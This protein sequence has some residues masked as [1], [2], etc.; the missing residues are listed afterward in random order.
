MPLIPHE[1]IIRG[2]DLDDEPFEDFAISIR[3]YGVVEKWRQYNH[4]YLYLNGYKY[5]TM[6]SPIPETIVIN[7]QKIFNEYDQIAEVYDCL[8]LKNGFPDENK[9]VA[10]LIK[11]KNQPV[12]EIGCGTGLLLEMLHIDKDRYIGIDPSQKMIEKLKEKHPGYNTINKPFE[13]VYYKQLLD[14]SYCISIFGSPSYIMTEYLQKINKHFPKLF[15][16]FYKPDYH[17][18]TYEKTKREFIHFTY[19]K[20]ELEYYFLG[21]EILEFNN[22]LIVR[23]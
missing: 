1:Y 13:E 6:G 10:N 21:A 17:P 7:R 5:W 20:I 16:M 15:L 18:V 12:C 19:S 11:Y 22:Y 23:R 8:F 2:R 9:A 4:S 14:F 3:K